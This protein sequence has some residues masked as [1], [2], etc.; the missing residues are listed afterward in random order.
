MVR[1]S[2]ERCSATQK[3]DFLRS[4]Q[5][6]LTRISGNAYDDNK[7][8]VGKHVVKGA[9]TVKADMQ[10]AT[11]GWLSALFVSVIILMAGCSAKEPD[12]TQL[13]ADLEKILEE[14]VGK[15]SVG[16]AE[17]YRIVSLQVTKS[18]SEDENHYTMQYKGEVECL[19]GFY[20]SAD[21]TYSIS[22]PTWKAA[23]H[24]TKGKLIG[25]AGSM[26]YALTGSDWK[27][28]H[29]ST[30]MNIKYVPRI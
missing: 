22:R 7:D 14:N 27:S 29:H 17:I 19:K 21:G 18:V 26:N 13:R 2:D 20:M 1:R 30:T 10:F 11:R 5:S 24:V 6:C 3:L 4:H 8:P 16:N 15:T 12:A 9:I 25:F 28:T 23:R